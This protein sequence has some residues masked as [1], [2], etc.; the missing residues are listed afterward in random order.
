M[1][2]MV[3][4]I[5]IIGRENAADINIK[6]EAF[7]RFGHMVPTYQNDQWSYTIRESEAVTWQCF[8]DEHY[9]FESMERDFVFIGAYVD[10]VCVG[11]A[12]LENQ[13]H[14]YMYLSDLKVNSAWR[15]Q[16]IAS[17]ILDEACRYAYGKG[18]R[19]IWT[20]GQDNNPGACLFYIKNGFRIGGLDTEVYTGTNQ[21]GKKNIY[22]YK[23]A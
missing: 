5:K 21:E 23:D 8:P 15:R 19:G 4:K 22:F 13:W 6:N 10:E 3:S 17:R 18:Y 16:N 11:L 9:D 20:I 14:K 2:N 1:K 12:V 7:Q